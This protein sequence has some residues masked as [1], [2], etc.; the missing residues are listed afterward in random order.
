MDLNSFHNLLPEYTTIKIGESVGVLQSI[1]LLAGGSDGWNTAS[2]I[3]VSTPDKMTYE[4]K[5]NAVI[6]KINDIIICTSAT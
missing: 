2:S 5:T 3:S 4:F 6:G 1:T